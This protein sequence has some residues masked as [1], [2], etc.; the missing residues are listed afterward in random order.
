MASVGLPS[1]KLVA[2]LL[3]LSPGFITVKAVKHRGKVTHEIDRFDKAIYT[4]LAS[5]LSIAIVI[6]IVSWWRSQNASATLSSSYLLW[7]I[8][9]GFL[10]ATVIAAGSG[11]AL[12][13]V[14]DEQIYSSEDNRKDTVW[15]LI[16]SHSEEPREV[17][18]ITANDTEIHGYVYVN[19]SNPHGQDLLLEYPQRIE[20]ENGDITD[21]IPIGD[22]VFISQADFS[23]IYFESD[24]DI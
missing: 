20:R 12:G 24:I 11:W 15:S 16:F 22:Y 3:L 9:T 14:I 10:A 4:V 8:S 5:G 7:E 21:K 18:V 17:R 13:W 6:L 19:D 23:H 2:A 1:L